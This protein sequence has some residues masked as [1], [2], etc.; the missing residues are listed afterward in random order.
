MK[1]YIVMGQSQIT[2]FV[3]QVFQN[4]PD[5]EKFIADEK[6]K[7]GIDKAPYIEEHELH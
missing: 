2:N 7:S 3:M 1:I 6:A 5:A 4:K